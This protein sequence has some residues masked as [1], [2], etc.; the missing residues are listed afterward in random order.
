[1]LRPYPVGTRPPESTALPDVEGKGLEETLAILNK[2]FWTSDRLEGKKRIALP[3][4]GT[5]LQRF[6]QQHEQA[7]SNDASK[8]T[9]G[10]PTGIRDLCVAFYYRFLQVQI[11]P[12]VCKLGHCRP[13]WDHACK[14]DLPCEELVESMYFDEDSRRTKPR[15]THLDDDA[16]NKTTT[17]ECIV[18]SLMNVQ[19]NA[20]HPEGDAPN[21]CYPIKYGLKPERSLKIRIG[22]ESDDAVLQHFRG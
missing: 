3:A 19:V 18:A 1:M 10:D 14:Y 13:S 4:A 9:L 6:A 2:H 21:A 12:H 15:K 11:M 20:H 16:Y 5:F 8:I 22:H 7:K 17:V